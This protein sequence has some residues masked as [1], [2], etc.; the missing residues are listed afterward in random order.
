MP[1]IIGNF[2]PPN[3]KV[4][5]RA[6][7]THPAYWEYA[8]EAFDLDVV[9]YLLKPILFERFLRSVGKV[10]QLS[11]PP[12]LESN[13]QHQLLHSFDEAYIYLKEDREMVK[14]FLKDILF[15]E[16]LR[17]YVRK[18]TTRRNELYHVSE[19]QLFGAKA[20]GEEVLT[21]TSLL[22]GGIGKSIGIHALFRKSEYP[23]GSRLAATTKIKF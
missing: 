19:N 23:S 17:D 3:P 1:S 10:Y 4:R 2:Q 8:F 21:S 7:A 14:V 11:Q 6:V 22:S 9:D 18:S 20:A 16:S 13:L 15:I 12:E 5:P